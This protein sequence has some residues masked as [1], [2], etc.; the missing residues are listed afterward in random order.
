MQDAKQRSR[1]RVP[2]Q[3]DAEVT[4]TEQQRPAQYARAAPA[5]AQMVSTSLLNY[6]VIEPQLPAN[7]TRGIVASGAT[8][9][10]PF[11]MPA[12]SA[13]HLYHVFAH[14]LHI[15]CTAN[16]HTNCGM[17]CLPSR[18]A[19]ST[20]YCLGCHVQVAMKNLGSGQ[21]PCAVFAAVTW[22]RWKAP[23]HFSACRI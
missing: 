4:C 16:L 18:H 3:H 1:E 9:E 21:R 10:Q 14:L 23:Q 11:H 2:A 22:S 13:G 8:L 17:A 12:G 5:R 6:C 15:C 19:H 7:R 20:A